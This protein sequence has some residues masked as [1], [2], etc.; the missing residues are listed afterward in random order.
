MSDI[1]LKEYFQRQIIFALKT[2]PVLPLLNTTGDLEGV[3]ASERLGH[4]DGYATT[5]TPM[6]T[7]AE[8]RESG[9]ESISSAVSKVRLDCDVYIHFSEQYDKD[10]SELCALIRSAIHNCLANNSYTVAMKRIGGF[11]NALRPNDVGW[12]MLGQDKVFCI[13]VSFNCTYSSL[14]MLSV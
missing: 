8:T 2:A 3:Y 11:R 1:G 9:Y 6:I 5:A 14:V 4:L 13:N 10:A 7:V 12:G